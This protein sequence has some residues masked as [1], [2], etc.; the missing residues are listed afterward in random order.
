MKSPSNPGAPNAPGAPLHHL[1][2]RRGRFLSFL[3]RNQGADPDVEDVLQDAFLKSL[4]RQASLRDSQKI[5]AWFYRVLRNELVDRHRQAVRHRRAIE[6]LK[7]QGIEPC[8][9]DPPPISTRCVET[10]LRQLA[11]RH[12]DTLQTLCAV[13]GSLPAFAARAG[14]TVNHAT[15]RACRARKALRLLHE[16]DTAIRA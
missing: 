12:R 3:K 13:D 5:V 6:V 14:I 16:G 4:E 9:A 11:P 7:W 10:L 8:S 2:E 1:L 15:V